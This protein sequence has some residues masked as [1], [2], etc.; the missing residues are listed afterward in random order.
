M[1]FDYRTD[2]VACRMQKHSDQ[3]LNWKFWTVQVIRVAKCESFPFPFRRFLFAFATY[4]IE[5]KFNRA[6]TQTRFAGRF[7]TFRKVFL[8]IPNLNGRWLILGEYNL[9]LNLSSPSLMECEMNFGVWFLNPLKWT[10][11]SS[12]NC[13]VVI[14]MIFGMPQLE[15]KYLIGWF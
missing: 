15:F 10:G 7:Q 14:R 12:N 9:S 11:Y 3:C 4:W 1:L 5:V 8:N 6:W 13:T 2:F